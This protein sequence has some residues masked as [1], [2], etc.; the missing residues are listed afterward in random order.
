ML[1]FFR[2][3]LKLLRYIIPPVRFL[4][5][6]P[7]DEVEKSLYWV[8]AFCQICAIRPASLRPASIDVELSEHFSSLDPSALINT[9]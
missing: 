3:I 9:V 5:I 2:G 6:P 7:L 4:L 1:C 8:F